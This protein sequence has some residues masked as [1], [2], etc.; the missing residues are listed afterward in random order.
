MPE[1][2]SPGVYVEEVDKGTK[3]IEGAGTACA[4]FVGFAERGPVNEPTFIPNWTE[5]T[6]TFGGFLEGSYLANAVFGYFLNGGGRCYVTRLPGGGEEEEEKAKAALPSHSQASIESLSITAL[7][8]GPAGGDITVEVVKPEGEDVSEDLFNL[9]VRGGGVEETFE[10]LSFG[11]ARGVRN[12]L[13]VVNKQSKLIQVAEQESQL[14]IAERAPNPGTYQLAVAE[15]TTTALAPVSSDEIVGDA[16]ERTGLS[17][18]EVAD[19]VTMVCV[20]DLMALYQA[21]V[22]SMDG[23]KAVQLAMIAHCENMKDRFAVLDCPPGLKPQQMKEWRMNEAG[24]D[25][26]YGAVYYPWIRVADPTGKRDSILVPPSGYVTGVYARSDNERGVHKAPANEVVRGAMALEM[27]ITKGEQD[28]LN[29]IGVNCI[30]AFPGRGIR[31]WGA[32]TLSSD[33]S[34]RY[35]NVRRLFNFVEKSIQMGT[36]WIVFEPNDADLWARI[37]RDITAFLS[38]VWGSGAL[39]GATAAEAFYVKCDAEN[40]PA[41]T[42]DLGQVIIEIGMA[43]VKPA[44]FV[45]FRI[46]QWAN[47]SETSE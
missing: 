34:W 14:T 47:G 25:T 5:F 18:F 15:A 43:P 7:E 20:P 1:Y 24:Y 36:Q 29:P 27:Q 45:I 19:D 32:R 40:N 12:V 22:I 9:I 6:N 17:G 42:R 16:A 3:P 21:G 38:T 4:A 23:V 39:F 8:A 13:D 2:L 11:K 28:I 26:K 41:A 44:E 46:S 33:A 37:R 31:I 30:R 35:I 10:N